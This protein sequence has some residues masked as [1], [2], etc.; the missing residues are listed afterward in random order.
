MNRLGQQAAMANN[1][2]GVVFKD[3]YVYVED[4]TTLT[5]GTSQ[6]GNVNIQ[7]DSDFVIQ[8]LTYVALD[9]LTTSLAAA[10]AIVPLVTMQITDSGSG[11]TFFEAATLISGIFGNGELPFILPT[12]K[13]VPARSTLTVTLSNI[14]TSIDYSRIS[15]YFIGYKVFRT[16]MG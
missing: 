5:N 10:T 9:D 11:R 8:K 2:S 1:Q 16:G 12:P 14:S 3:F 13:L 15:V 7:A 4:F 6:T